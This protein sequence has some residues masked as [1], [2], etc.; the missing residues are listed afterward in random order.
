MVARPPD[1]WPSR[2]LSYGIALAAIG[3]ALA[4][5]L[6][7]DPWLGNAV[8]FT[9]LYGAIAATAWWG[10]WRPAGVAALVGGAACQVMFIEPRGEL[11]LD[12][13]ATRIAAAAYLVTC[14]L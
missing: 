2:L 14:A 5:R 8:P 7:L 6:L 1:P 4:A 13:P 3:V 9:T 11:G 12:L 10:G